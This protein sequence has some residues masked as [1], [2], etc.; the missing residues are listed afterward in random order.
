MKNNILKDY[1]EFLIEIKNKIRLSQYEAIKKVNHTLLELYWDIGKSIVEKQNKLG[2]GKSVVEKLSKDL[3]LEFPDTQGY[4]TDNLWR[5]RKFYIHY[6]YNTKLAPLVQEISWSHN[7]IILER[8]KDDLK[9][10]YYVQM[11]RKNAW[12]KSVLIHQILGKSYKNLLPTPEEIKLSLM[13]YCLIW[14]DKLNKVSGLNDLLIII[15]SNTKIIS[16][17][18]GEIGCFF[19]EPFNRGTCFP[20]GIFCINKQIVFRHP[21][22][23]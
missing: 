5:M 14:I 10:E 4:S 2:W 7:I 13:V 19:I 23:C 21:S 3:I 11:I 15:I 20:I 12:S 9:R 18:K 1:K 6:Q 22:S 16:D 17:C 8:C